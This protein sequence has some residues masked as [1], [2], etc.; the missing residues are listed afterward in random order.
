LPEPYHMLSAIIRRYMSSR[1]DIGFSLI[2]TTFK[3][4]FEMVIFAI[5]NVA[6]LL[7]YEYSMKTYPMLSSIRCV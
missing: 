7:C 2:I 6:S 5:R 1:M 4:L 3:G